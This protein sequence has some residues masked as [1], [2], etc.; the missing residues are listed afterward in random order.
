MFKNFVTFSIFD[1]FTFQQAD[2]AALLDFLEFLV[3]NQVSNESIDNYLSAIKIKLKILGLDTT[4]L[5]DPRIKYFKRSLAI[6]AP[7]RVIIKSIIDIALIKAV[8]QQC[9]TL[10]MGLVYKAAFLLSFYSFL[11]ISNLV[12]HSMATWPQ[13]I[14]AASTC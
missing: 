5:F 12:S 14:T 3:F 10:C 6:I 2:S 1:N 8:A 9:D 11:R 13:S 4:P 7:F